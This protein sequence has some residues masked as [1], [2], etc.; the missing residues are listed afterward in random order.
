MTRPRS[1]ATRR[2][3]QEA[4]ASPGPRQQRLVGVQQGGV[5]GVRQRR[6]HLA[7]RRRRLGEH[8]QRLV[9]VG[10][11]D[12]GVEGRGPRRC[13]RRPRRRCAVSAHRGDLGAEADVVERARRPG[14]RT[15]ATR[16]PPSSTRGDP[17]TPSMPWWSRKRE[18]VAR[19]VVQRDRRVARPDRGDDGLHEVPGEV[20]REA[21]RRRGTS[22]SV[23]SSPCPR[24][25]GARAAPVEARDLGEH[26]QVRRPRAGCARSGTGRPRPSA[27]AHSRPVASS[28]VDIDISESWVATPSSANIRS[29]VG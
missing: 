15:S 6:Q 23:V 1:S 3:F 2:K 27:P 7:L 25:A 21:V 19:R 28:R 13:R 4:R 10:G 14:R 5:G 29:S 9:G 16:R 22:R 11:D 18:Q 12:D 17:K 20:R 26:P 8:R 24:R